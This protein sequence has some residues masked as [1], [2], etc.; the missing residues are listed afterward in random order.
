MLLVEMGLGQHER[1]TIVVAIKAD[2]REDCYAVRD[3]G[4]LMG[5]PTNGF[6]RCQLH[7]CSVFHHHQKVTVAGSR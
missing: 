5:V 4:T 1:L 3:G 7:I 6:A 2:V